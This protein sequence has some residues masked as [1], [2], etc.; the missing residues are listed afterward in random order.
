M[1]FITNF[2]IDDMCAECYPCDHQVTYLQITK[3]GKQEHV[4]QNWNGIMIY[5]FLTKNNLL[6]GEPWWR[7]HF[8]R[9]ATK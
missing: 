7:G 6:D 8:G 4:Q 9:Y 1:D 2:E 3:N 5:D